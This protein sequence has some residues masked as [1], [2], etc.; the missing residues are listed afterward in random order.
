ME[1]IT[2][3]PQI[4]KAEIN[5]TTGLSDINSLKTIKIIVYTTE[6]VTILEKTEFFESSKV[7]KAK[8]PLIKY[9]IALIKMNIKIFITPF[10]KLY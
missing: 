8:K 2:K 1:T 9:R 5:V 4:A 10:I 3:H 6:D 7:K